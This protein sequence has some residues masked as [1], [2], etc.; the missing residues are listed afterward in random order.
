M[1]HWCPHLKK[2]VHMDVHGHR[3]HA[4]GKAEPPPAGSLARGQE[5][6]P[7]WGP[8]RPPGEES[9]VLTLFPLKWESHLLDP[10]DPGSYRYP[11]CDPHSIPTVRQGTLSS[12][13]LDVLTYVSGHGLTK[14]ISTHYCHLLLA[15]I[16]YL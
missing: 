14:G 12:S 1:E 13:G 16:I 3:Y 9:W 6:R 15:S 11:R 2:K 5:G 7:P 8:E 4:K 10:K